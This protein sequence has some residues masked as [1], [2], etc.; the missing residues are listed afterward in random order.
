MIAAIILAAGESRRLSTPKQLVP[1]KGR[2]LIARSVDAA[3]GSRCD[4]IIVVLGAHAE[5][6]IPEIRDMCAEIACNPDWQQGKATTI[7][8]GMNAVTLSPTPFDSVILMTCDQPHVDSA[9]LNAIIDRHGS[10]PDCIVACEYAGTTGVPALVPRKYFGDLLSLSGEEGAKS[11]IRTHPE[12]TQTIHFPDG[13]LDIDS[14]RDLE[15]L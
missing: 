3:A 2:T 11:L 12:A 6:I 15:L 14:P 9:L 5:S 8:A 7:K 13:A 10:W 1:Y 4:H